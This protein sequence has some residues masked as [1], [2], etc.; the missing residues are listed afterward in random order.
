MTEKELIE[1]IES[2][3]AYPVPMEM[4]KDWAKF[5]S[6]EILALIKEALPELGKFKTQEEAYFKGREDGLMMAK[7]AGKEECCYCGKKPDGAMLMMGNQLA[8]ADCA[9]RKL[10]ELLD[11]DYDG[12]SEPE[13]VVGYLAGYVRLDDVIE[14]KVEVLGS[15]T[16]LDLRRVKRL[17]QVGGK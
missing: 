3:L 7:E 15:G 14:G 1:K 11:P 16:I 17:K 2:I 13:K 12:T 6:S 9:I 10:N 5:A 4:R 8:H